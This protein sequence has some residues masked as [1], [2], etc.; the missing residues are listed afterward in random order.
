MHVGQLRKEFDD[1]LFTRTSSGLAF[2]P[3]GLRLASRAVEIL[4][5]QDRTVREVSQ[6]G[7]G[8]PGAAGGDVEP[9]RRARRPGA[10][11]AVREPRR[12]PRGRAERALGRGV[13]RAARHPHRRRRDRP[14]TERADRRRSAQLPFLLYEVQAVAGPDAPAG[15][16]HPDHRPDPAP[17]LEPRPVGGRGRRRGARDA[18]SGSAYPSSSSGSSRATPPRSRRP[19]AATGSRSPSAS[20]SSGDLSAGRLVPL[21][22]PGLRAQGRWT[23]L[24]LAPGPPDAGRRRAAALHHHAAGDPGHGPR[25]RR[26]PRPVQAGGARHPLELTSRRSRLRRSRR[27]RPAARAACAP[28]G[29]RRSTA[30]PPPS[31]RPAARSRSRPRAGSARPRG[32]PAAAPWPSR[33]PAP[34][35]GRCPS[36]RRR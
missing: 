16:A 6:A 20:R 7:H 31:T 24:A 13:P 32:V 33:R 22:G 29:T 3:G 10:D 36:R 4:G 27:T 2:T 8:L 30:A 12:R 15:R 21:E 1:L 5:L 25:R 34:R 19:P 23:A 35:A 28:A 17:E 11:R 26:A 14:R 9:V 18:A